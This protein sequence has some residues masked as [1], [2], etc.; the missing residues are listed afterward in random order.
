MDSGADTMLTNVYAGD[1]A[2]LLSQAREFGAYQKM[3]IACSSIDLE[4][5]YQLGN[6]TIRGLYGSPQGWWTQENDRFQNEF[7]PAFREQLDRMPGQGAPNIYAGM[8]EAFTVMEEVG[9]FTA[10]EEIVRELEGREWAIK[11]Y[12]EDRD[13]QYYR[14]CDH[15]CPLPIPV[16]EA[17]SADDAENQ[18]DLFN[19]LDYVPA[20][21]ATRACEDTG[22]SLPDY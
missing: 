4:S 13:G 15:R 10:S 1:L 2:T 19:I 11:T 9:D 14:K 22:C 17:K 12:G 18:Y 5:I 3:D 6:E 20:E 8:W 21:D 7:L 16:A